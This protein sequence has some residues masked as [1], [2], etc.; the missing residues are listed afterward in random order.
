MTFFRSLSLAIQNI[1]SSKMRSFLTMLGVI[2]G[3]AAVF[4]IAGMSNGMKQY[5]KESFA[6]LGTN[7]LEL[8]AYEQDP[9]KKVSIEDIEKFVDD[10]SDSFV[11]SSPKI[12]A[13]Y[14]IKY[15][16]EKRQGPIV[17]VSE[18]FL[19][20]MKYEIEKGRNITYIDILNEKNVCVLGAYY[21]KRWFGPDVVGKK[22]SIQGTTF[23]VIG[24]VKQIEDSPL[25]NEYTQDGNIYLP[26]STAS[27]MNNEGGVSNFIL[28]T[29]DDIDPLKTK[30]K[31]ENYLRNDLGITEFWIMSMAEMLEESNKMINIISIVLG[32]IAS[33]SLLVGGIGIMNIMLVSVTERT[34][35]I[36]I[37]KSL[38]AKNKYILE[39]FIIEAGV[40]S[41]L[42]GLIGILIG[43]GLS[44][45][46]TIIV[47]QLTQ[48]TI[49]IVPSA[50]AVALAFGI[51]VFIGVFFGFLPAR[52]AANL[53]PIDALRFT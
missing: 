48:Q 1:L 27:A 29:K 17:G 26:Y 47:R 51:S 7:T 45:I 10:N 22:I 3:V 46:A 33:I 5:V 24:T 35:E 9:S 34:R 8:E 32:V 38:G 20:L 18:E 49:V 23:T 53:N 40:T 42:G 14:N 52:K 39:Q 15:K 28:I 25:P 19:G 37:R 4:V 2:I 50:L 11:G 41:G 6:D 43:Y 36:G 16:K 30:A 44:A 31:L 13:Y 21:S 12:N